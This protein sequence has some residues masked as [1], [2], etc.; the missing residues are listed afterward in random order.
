MAFI[1]FF[2]AGSAR[3]LWLFRL[4]TAV[5][6]PL[7]ILGLLEAA[8][9]LSHFGHPTS[10]LVPK[11]I[12]GKEMLVDNTWFGLRFFPPALARSPN[13]IAIQAQKPPGVFRIFLFGESAA[14]GDPR[15]AYGVGRCL[16]TL[17]RERFPGVEF[18]VVCVAMTA[19]NSH[20]ILPIARECAQYQGDLWIVYMGNNEFIGPFGANTVF[21]PKAPSTWLVRGYL[22]LQRTRVGQWIVSKVRQRSKGGAEPSSWG[23][24]KMFADRHLAPGNPIKERIYNHFE[25]NLDDIIQAGRRSGVPILLSSVAVNVKDCAPFGSLHEP[26]LTVSNVLNWERAVQEGAANA[27]REQWAAAITHYQEAIRMSPNY[28]EMHFRRGQCLLGMSNSLAAKL[29][30]ERARDLDA[31][32]FRAD[33]RINNLI[34]KAGERYSGKG[35][36]YLD[37]VPVLATSSPLLTPGEESFYEHVHMNFEGNYRLACA[38]GAQIADLLP[39][40]IASRCAPAWAS[41]ETCS[42][43]LGLTDWNQ[44]TIFEEIGRRLSDTPYTNQFN[45][46]VRYRKFQNQMA[47]LK[48]NLRPRAAKEAATTFQEEIDKHPGEHWLHHNYAEFLTAIGD[49]P[50][51]TKQMEAVRDLLPHH[52]AAYFQLGK[53]LARQKKYDDARLSLQASLRL[54]PDVADVYLELGQV[55]FSQ[56]KLEEAMPQYIAAQNCRPG[57]ARPHLLMAYLQEKQKNRGDAIRSLREA[58]RLKPAYWEARSQ[59]G[60]ELAL[61]GKFSEAQ[62]HFEEAL[63]LRPDDPEGHLNL[64]IAL[65]RQERFDEAIGHLEISLSLE[66]GNASTRDF[67]ANIKQLKA[68]KNAPTP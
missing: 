65:A 23:G 47:E 32:P 62:M 31:L 54:R 61:D 1:T 51:A 48:K 52:H 56:G 60:V 63:R 58:I 29:S 10:F 2:P 3:R 43:R 41:R 37:A 33:A 27:A 59:L 44:F 35:V 13:P 34:A 42:K 24:L 28:A 49:L 53:L 18:E 68:Q 55:L 40:K 14:M 21:G 38:L 8:L 25:R 50:N 26:A 17:L 12:N 64:G 9:R 15:P 20:V 5:I 19:I 67:I 36:A 4:L 39:P 57:D 66:P 6:L 22:T 30:F 16:E 11:R 7:T 46:E 45:H